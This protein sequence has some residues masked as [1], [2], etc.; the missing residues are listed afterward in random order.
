MAIAD[1]ATDGRWCFV[2]LWVRPR[3]IDAPTPSTWVLL[4]QRLEEVCPSALPS[5]LPAPPPP[6]HLSKRLMLLQVCSIDRTG[7]L[8]GDLNFNYSCS[9]FLLDLDGLSSLE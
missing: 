1:L 3:G 4:K 7:L 8:N 6:V 9:S 2:A 5:L